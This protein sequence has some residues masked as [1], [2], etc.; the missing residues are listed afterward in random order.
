MV[1]Q[2]GR[3]VSKVTDATMTSLHLELQRCT[4]ASYS[5][6]IWCDS[7]Y[8]TNDPFPIPISRLATTL[9]KAPPVCTLLPQLDTLE[10]FYHKLIGNE[11][12]K[13]CPDMLLLQQTSTLL[14][15][16][17]STVEGDELPDALSS[18]ILD[19]LEKAKTPFSRSGTRPDAEHLDEQQS[20]INDLEC[21]PCLPIVRSHGDYCLDNT[22]PYENICTKTSSQHCSLLSGIFLVH[23]KHGTIILCFDINT[24][25]EVTIHLVHTQRTLISRKFT[26]QSGSHFI[27]NTM[28]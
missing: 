4:P 8:G 23:C 15:D 6:L 21:Y 14:S 26:L 18:L 20:H 2:V 24:L 19:L 16:V 10:E 9:G 22:T 27:T 28:M 5:F 13:E 11:P 17:A 25:V 7:F 1:D 3:D 12:L